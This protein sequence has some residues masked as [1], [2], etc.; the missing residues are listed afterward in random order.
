VNGETYG[1]LK[2]LCEQVVNDFFPER[3]LNIRPGLIVGP[4]DPTDR[5]TYWPYRIARGG[6]I[7]VPE[8]FP[9]QIIDARDLAEWNVRLVEAG[10][11][12]DY[13]A[14]GP[15]YPLRMMEIAAVC[16]QVSDSDARFVY[17]DETFLEQEE[18]GPWMEMPLWVPY[19]SSDEYAGFSSV[20]VD[21]AINDGLTFRSMEDT[22]RDTLEWVET[23]PAG[24]EIKAGLKPE[25]ER[26]LLQKWAEK[27][28]ES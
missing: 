17:V 2:V 16:R 15:D 13:N 24:Y 8:D 28:E 7:L 20:N 6:D 10:K 26:E 4:H 9:V 27:A 18:V 25:R 22:V 1:P 21:K 19:K 14:T 12:G 5:F 23:W 3:T 11:T